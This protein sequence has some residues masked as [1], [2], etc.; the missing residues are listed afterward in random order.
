MQLKSLQLCYLVPSLYIN[1]MSFAVVCVVGTDDFQN[2]HLH[3][4]QTILNVKLVTSSHEAIDVLEPF[5][6]LILVNASRG[7]AEQPPPVNLIAITDYGDNST[8]DEIQLSMA[9]CCP[10]DWNEFISTLGAHES[11]SDQFEYNEQPLLPS[12]ACF[13]AAIS[14][15]YSSYGNKLLRFQITTPDCRN[16]STS[17]HII[18]KSIKAKTLEE[19]IG[20]IS[21][22]R[23]PIPTVPRVT[24]RIKFFI[25]IERVLSSIQCTLF[26]DT[27]TIKILLQNKSH[28]L[29]EWVPPFNRNYFKGHYVHTFTRP[30][31]HSFMM[32]LEAINSGSNS[33]G[34]SVHRVINISV[35]NKDT[36]HLTL[37]HKQINETRCFDVMVSVPL[38]IEFDN[39]FNS[40]L[41][42]TTVN[43]D[44]VGSGLYLISDQETATDLFEQVQFL[45][46]YNESYGNLTVL[47]NFGDLSPEV[48]LVSIADVNDFLIWDSTR[49]IWLNYGLINHSY[50]H[51]SGNFEIK[52]AILNS[53]TD[54][55]HLRGALG[56][57]V[58]VRSIKESVELM[59]I[60]V[61][62]NVE[63]NGD[64]VISIFLR[65]LLSFMTILLRVENGIV[66]TRLN[67][68]KN[69]K[70]KIM[71][72]V[73]LKALIPMEFHSCSYMSLSVVS[74]S[75][76][77]CFPISVNITTSSGLE[78]YAATTYV[79]IER[80]NIPPL[81][82]AVIVYDDD[83]LEEYP[84]ARENV[85]F[86]FAVETVYEGLNYFVDFGDGS[87]V[88]V[89]FLSGL[90]LP[91][92][93]PSNYFQMAANE[94]SMAL[95]N[96]SFLQ[97][98]RYTVS[99]TVL[100]S[101][102]KNYLT[103][104]LVLVHQT[105]IVVQR[106]ISPIEK[107][108][109]RV[110]SNHKTIFQGDFVLV[111]VTYPPIL[112]AASLHIFFGDSC[113]TTLQL[114][115]SS[116]RAYSI[117]RS[118]QEVVWG[119]WHVYKMAGT[120]NLTV[121]M[122]FDESATNKPTQNFAETIALE[123]IA[124]EPS[125]GMHIFRDLNNRITQYSSTIFALLITQLLQPAEICVN[126]G[127]GHVLKHI[128]MDSVHVLPFWVSAHVVRLD[129]YRL[130]V[131][132]TYAFPG[133]YTIELA[134]LNHSTMIRVNVSSFLNT[135]GHVAILSLNATDGAASVFAILMQDIVNELRITINFGDNFIRLNETVNEM[136]TDYTHLGLR[137]DQSLYKY[138]GLS[139][140]RYTTYGSFEVSV[141]V[142]NNIAW[143]FGCLKFSYTH[144]LNEICRKPS[145]SIF[146]RSC[147]LSKNNTY[148]RRDEIDLHAILQT[149]CNTEHEVFFNYLWSV[150][151]TEDVSHDCL[152][153]LANQDPDTVLMK[154]CCNSQL[155]LPP[156]SL[157]FGFYCIILE[158][159]Y[160]NYCVTSFLKLAC[161]VKHSLL[162]FVKR[163]YRPYDCFANK[164]RNIIAI[165][166]YFTHCNLNL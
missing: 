24:D 120:F 21:F 146:C 5:L 40:F 69:Q 76:N 78:S 110:E 82:S 133:F 8:V 31:M 101:S 17:G 160:F 97:A 86:L 89:T 58:Y 142:G 23:Q 9:S 88:N 106:L 128:D 149:N 70:A 90:T 166:I 116:S 19:T 112:K 43:C 38:H 85:N 114:R 158:V 63:T 119:F 87:I 32:K 124:L 71:S 37:F 135:V 60:R 109:I 129:V 143:P 59:A 117:D 53:S 123:I 144:I 57:S 52:L 3:M 26:T 125:V 111:I 46:L 77:G 65:K 48:A 150:K 131:G 138:V 95:L 42:K 98:G 7:T 10:G 103:P 79:Y 157:E 91:H 156:F 161:S 162:L 80:A 113:Q 122:K 16:A 163:S 104:S 54:G 145:V 61:N 99:L 141:T 147:D 83:S 56:A 154:E 51:T 81:G 96:H 121:E 35:I 102:E 151:K 50:S 6:A 134:A 100:Q 73:S 55:L 67:V 4:L 72:A 30:G 14:H 165:L 127:D 1:A 13:V 107:L 152:I 44:V 115:D 92:W 126:F 22:I 11:G 15:I 34:F 29:P 2:C 18:E 105:S 130:V 84:G 68:T 148:E 12:E 20:S 132:H 62:R 27:S 159:S 41:N 45:V 25:G 28:D 139:E 94:Y 137:S 153:N 93:I 136:L 33:G 140:H 75:K 39:I 66:T 164:C 47:V 64:S 108:S 49:D 74:F 118:T 36:P 155:L